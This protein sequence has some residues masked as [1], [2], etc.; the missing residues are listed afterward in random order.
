MLD[1][2]CF[3]KVVLI[4]SNSSSSSE[5]F[6]EVSKGCGK[7]ETFEAFYRN[8]GSFDSERQCFTTSIVKSNQVIN[9]VFTFNGTGPVLSNRTSGDTKVSRQEELCICEGT[10]CNHEQEAK[11][12]WWIPLVVF[13]SCM[14]FLLIVGLI[15]K[16]FCSQ[17]QVHKSICTG[18]SPQWAQNTTK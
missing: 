11:M 8:S 12:Q 13:C 15:R 10:N 17:M 16:C 2:V 1:D 14:A 6:L 4:V 7:R 18:S 5:G 3:G 9:N